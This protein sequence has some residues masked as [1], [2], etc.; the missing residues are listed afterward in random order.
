MLKG[1]LNSTPAITVRLASFLVIL[2][3]HGLP[4][5]GITISGREATINSHGADTKFLK[6]NVE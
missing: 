3:N 2:L 1:T 6:K 4:C 5:R